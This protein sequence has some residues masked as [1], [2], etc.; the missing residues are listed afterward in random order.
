MALYI[1]SSLY[2]R[3]HATHHAARSGCAADLLTPRIIM[4]RDH[5]LTT[6]TPRCRWTRIKTQKIVQENDQHQHHTVRSL[7][8]GR[9]QYHEQPDQR[10][11]RRQAAGPSS[12]GIDSRGARQ[13]T[14]MVCSKTVRVSKAKTKTL[15]VN[16]FILMSWEIHCHDWIFLHIILKS[17]V[18]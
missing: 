16:I 10:R 4:Q 2:T 14:P 7:W 6:A 8:Y 1:C 5:S 13:A 17:E 3:P 18:Q 11:E 15:R 12:T 9:L